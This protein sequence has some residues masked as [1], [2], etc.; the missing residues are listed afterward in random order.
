MFSLI[1]LQNYDKIPPPPSPQPLKM[2]TVIWQHTLKCWQRPSPWSRQ[3]TKTACGHH[4]SSQMILQLCASGF[5]SICNGRELRGI[6]I[7]PGCCVV[8]IVKS[9]VES[10]QIP[11]SRLVVAQ[12][13]I[14]VQA[15]QSYRARE[16]RRVWHTHKSVAREGN[17]SRCWRPK[18][19]NFYNV[20]I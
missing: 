1:K 14:Y 8:Q 18:T 20:S 6:Q 13:H 9:K 17:M 16:K 10:Y 7:N 12:F 11:F 3:R 19:R 15:I 2:L 4:G 5:E